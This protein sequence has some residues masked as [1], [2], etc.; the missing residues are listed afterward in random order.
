MAVLEAR[1]LR[2]SYGAQEVVAGGFVAADEA[3]EFFEQPRV[4]ATL[5]LEV[6]HALASRQGDGRLEEVFDPRRDVGL[7]H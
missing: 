7:S 1:S 6:S 5:R 4:V 3:L 2:K